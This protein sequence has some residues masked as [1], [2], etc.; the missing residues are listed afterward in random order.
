MEILKIL[1]RLSLVSAFVVFTSHAAEGQTIDLSVEGLTTQASYESIV[2]KLGKPVS[3]RRTGNVP[4]GEAMRI[5]RYPG[6]TLK[7]EVGSPQPFGLYR[8]KVTSRRWLVS[9]LSVGD[10]KATIIK[11]FGRGRPIRDG[12]STYLGYL[13]KEGYAS[14]HIRQNRVTKIEWEFNFC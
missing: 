4:C 11:R 3:D 6:L 7:L 5:L 13:M 2:R 8:I 12:N 9:D 1:K 14:F 10:S